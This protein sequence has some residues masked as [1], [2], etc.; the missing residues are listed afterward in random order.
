MRNFSRARENLFNKG[1]EFQ[2]TKNDLIIRAGDVPSGIYYITSGWVQIFTICDDGEPNILFTLYS[3]DI[4]PLAWAT[5][6]VLLDV[7]FS[8]LAD[9]KVLRIPREQYVEALNGDPD[10]MAD[11]IK[12]LSKYSYC[13]T[14]ELDNLQYR[15]ARQRVCYRLFVLASHFGQRT[16]KGI[17]INQAVSN[18]YIARSTNM[19]RETA[20]REITS[21]ARQHIIFMSGNRITIADTRKL[22]Q[23]LHDDKSYSLLNS[24]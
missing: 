23:A 9:T 1:R 15:T 3:G 17:Q 21:L 11:T 4:F 12:L 14:E 22:R 2:Y 19:T 8:A 16:E 18:E 10:I 5:T 20:S 13:F 24:L 7:N 6:G